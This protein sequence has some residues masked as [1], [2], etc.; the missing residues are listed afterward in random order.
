MKNNITVIIALLLTFEVMAQGAWTK[1]KGGG[2]F[3]L[4]ETVIVS[5]GFF[6]PEGDIRDIKT[7]GVYISSVY[8]EYGITDRITAI[9]YVPF[10]VRNTINEQEFAISPNIEEA[11]EANSFGDMNIGLQV[12][13]LKNGPLVLSSSLLLGLP[14]GETAGGNS[15]LLQSGDGEFNQLLR[16]HA[17]YSFYPKPY[18]AAGYVG[19]NNRTDGFS[20]EF[21][22]GLEAGTTINSWFIA[23]KMD[24][25]ESLLNGDVEASQTGIFSNNTEFI[26]FGPEVAYSLGNG[27][28]VSGSI[29][30][31]FK[32]Q[33]ILASPSLTLGL[34]YELK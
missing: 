16:L 28:G 18:Y 22:L 30:G 25:V 20:D 4:A 29:L 31:A 6:N 5:D 21:R 7:T 9:A 19:I 1:P 26:S 8:A 2:F 23:L 32:G 10:F 3:K 14:T 17:G 15:Q 34:I 13:I 12:G 24:W 27:F 33:N 11:D